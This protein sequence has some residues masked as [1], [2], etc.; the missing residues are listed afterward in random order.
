MHQIYWQ[1]HLILSNVDFLVTVSFHVVAS[2]CRIST[3]L[4]NQ[5][6]NEN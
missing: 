1:L 5:E 6:A 4:A 2:V 3:Y